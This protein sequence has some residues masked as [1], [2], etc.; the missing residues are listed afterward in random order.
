MNIQIS[1]LDNLV[2][3]PDEEYEWVATN[4]DPQF[5]IGPV[6]SLKGREIRISLKLRASKKITF[7][8]KLYWDDGVGGLSES[9]SQDF[10]LNTDGFYSANLKIPDNVTLIRLDPLG[11]SCKFSLE[12]FLLNE[13]AVGSDS[14]L[15][16]IQKSYNDFIE[17]FEIKK[18][19]YPKY[20]KLTEQWSFRPKISIVMPAYNTPVS[21]L[22]SAINSVLCQTYENWEL[23]IVDD[24]ST[25]GV[26][27]DY[28]TS[29]SSLDSRVKYI[30]RSAN[31][32]MGKASNTGIQSAS[33]DYVGFLDH[34]DELHPMA[35][36][37]IVEAFI[38]NPQIKMVYSDEDFI[39]EFGGRYA[40]YFKCDFNYDLM[41]GHNMITHFMAFTKDALVQLEGFSLNHN[42]AQDYDLV[43][44]AYEKFGPCSFYHVPHVLY[45]WRVHESSTSSSLTAKPYAHLAAMRAIKEHLE[46]V[47]V[48]AQVEPHLEA[49]GCNRV[50]YSLPV[51]LPSVEIIIP[52]KDCLSLLQQCINSILTKSTYTNYRILIVDNG[53]EKEE[54]LRYFLDLEEMQAVSVV[55]DGR[56]FNFSAINNMA[57]NHS[58]ADYV[59]LLN[60][61]IEVITPSWIEEMLSIGVQ[62]NVGCVGA[63]LWY[64]DNTLQHGGLIMGLGGVAG[65]SHKHL[66]KGENGYANRA[67]LAQS[68][69]GVTAACLLVARKIFLEVGGMDEKFEV[70]FN[71]VDFCL[72]VKSRGYRNVW[73]PHAELFHHESASRGYED[74]PEKKARF[75]NEAMRLNE[76]WGDGLHV[77]PYYSPSLTLGSEDFGYAWPPRW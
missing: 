22:E 11:I 69:S 33:G 42:G 32:H 23:C 56:K 40:P 77:D 51:K 72:K 12:N 61:D 15:R 8:P 41:L 19:D 29:V 68:F 21:F 38:N 2:K 73:T 76:V 36:Y 60:N 64:P 39:G 62:P 27:K 6:D 26:I 16:I 4:M 48:D 58:N 75:H 43:L 63:R 28:A 34:D 53:S 47:G 20:R 45:H 7:G 14:N 57:V 59:L 35:L 46:R 66:P 71:D 52:T 70:A 74:T 9:N 24:A 25:D 67:V 49:P 13:S 31:G 55:K 54:T 30:R 37:F 5:L 18:A 50:K 17:N 10:L 44:R 65:H 1:P 3:C